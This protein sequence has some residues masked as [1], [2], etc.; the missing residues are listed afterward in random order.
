MS[1]QPRLDHTR[2]LGAGDA[3]VEHVDGRDLSCELAAG[4]A[5]V[6]HGDGCDHMRPSAHAR[7]ASSGS[8]P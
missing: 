5:E 7:K 3:E 8:Q 1:S 6:E 4:D 2:D